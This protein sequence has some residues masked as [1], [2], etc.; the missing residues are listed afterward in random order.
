MSG[1]GP[2]PDYLRRKRGSVFHR[3]FTN[4]DAIKNF[5]PPVYQ[6]SAT[7]LQSLE[8]LFSNSFLTK[9]V[10]HKNHQVLA[11]AMFEKKFD[12]G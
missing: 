11:Q 2:S 4:S 12:A 1:G 9:G 3:A 6:K 7:S 5:T 10:D 8:Q